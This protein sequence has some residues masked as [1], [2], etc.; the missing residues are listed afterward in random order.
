MEQQNV[1]KMTA[2]NFQQIVVEMS[3]Q[4]LVMVGFWSSRDQ[5]CVDLMG[6]LTNLAANYSQDLIFASVDVD[7]QHQIA[8]Q[9]GIQSVP[10]V[11]LVKDSRPIDNF[12]GG[13]TVAEIEAFLKPHLPKEEDALLAQC[14]ALIASGDYSSAFGVAKKAYELDPER[15]ELK[16]AYVDVNIHTGKLDDAEQL[17]A[18]IKI[19]D[20]D[21]YYQSLV[22]ALE[23]AQ[24]ASQS[25]EIQTLE[26]AL[27]A[28]PDDNE[29]KEKLAVQLSQANR[30]EEALDLLLGILL[31]DMAFGQSK[32]LYLDI[33]AILP[34][35][36]PLAAKYRRKIYSLLY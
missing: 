32:K 22:A 28:A 21:S 26:Q 12:V 11:A 16:L 8:A 33:L 3:T 15:V 2:D 31:K 14:Q 10:T 35:G 9:F 19:I 1:I 5:G 29:I 6:D 25:P 30:N 36:D 18:T 34:D 13:K 7:E 17:L 24:S 23:L 27:D 4:K 20:Q